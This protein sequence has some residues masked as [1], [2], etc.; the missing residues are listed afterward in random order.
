[1][2]KFYGIF[3]SILLL[4]CFLCLFF[5]RQMPGGELWKGF[6]VLYVPESVSDSDVQNSFGQAG[7]NEVTCFSNQYL[8][9]DLKA[10]SCEIA[11]MSLNQKSMDYL[12][13]RNNYFF[14]KTHSYRLY[15]VPVYYKNKLNQVCSV[16][17]RLPEARNG[18]G[19]CGVDS[20]SE[21]PFIIPILAAIFA[22]LLIFFSK[23]KF[24]Y[25]GLTVLPVLFTFS[26]PFLSSEI[27]VFILLVLL[28]LISNIFGRRDFIKILLKKY[29]Y[30][31]LLGFSLLSVFSSGFVSGLI[32]IL[33]LLSE[34]SYF[35]LFRKVKILQYKK[36]HFNPVM[37]RSSFSVPLYGGK[38]KIIFGTLLGL[39]VLSF[40][41]SVLSSGGTD[42]SASGG[43]ISLPSVS[44]A[45]K[46][47]DLPD[48][49]E[50]Y[51]WD[52]EIRSFPYKSVN[53]VYENASGTEFSRF[54]K[55][56]D[57]VVYS[58]DVLEYS[59]S[60]AENVYNG[61]DLLQ[62]NAFEKI[63]KKQ[64]ESFSAGYASNGSHRL[65]LFCIIISFIQF[66]IILISFAFLLIKSTGKAKRGRK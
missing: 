65:S 42:N 13:K 8:P 27:A 45:R 54:E 32:F 60:Y 50:Y 44:A 1:M 16:L 6:S 4:S 36:N 57:S 46:S 64:G 53:Y 49:E 26:F 40:G 39:T 52:Y 56:G 66:A 20:K 62:F 37:I 7:I 28:F 11:L 21:Y 43:S 14:D 10:D 9:I 24:F 25:A 51:L 2:K 23:K 3:S 18:Q 30:M 34:Y 12:L 31:V 63:M 41:F 19:K 61:I 33:L 58:K 29:V 17:N 38:E 5:F 59:P 15:Y 55:N 22:G 47:A 48:L 35:Y